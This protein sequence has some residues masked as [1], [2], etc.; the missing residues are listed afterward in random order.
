MRKLFLLIFLVTT[1]LIADQPDIVIDKR[2]TYGDQ[3]S[4]YDWMIDSTDL[5]GWGIEI[6]SVVSGYYSYPTTKVAII[7]IGPGIDSLR[8][9]FYRSGLQMF[10]AEGGRL[11]VPVEFSY[12][13]TWY[14]WQHKC[15]LLLLNEGW[16]LGMEANNDCLFDSLKGLTFFGSYYSSS[17][18][19]PP[20]LDS[21]LA[22]DIDSLCL[23]AGPSVSLFFPAETLL[24]GNLSTYNGIFPAYPFVIGARSFYGDGE[25]IIFENSMFGFRYPEDSLSIAF[26]NT[27]LNHNKPYLRNLL[28]TPV[29]D[30]QERIFKGIPFFL[31]TQVE[32]I[33]PEDEPDQATMDEDESGVRFLQS[34]GDTVANSFEVSE[35]SGFFVKMDVFLGQKAV[36]D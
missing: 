6:D 12:Y 24:I 2:F 13:P 33:D 20:P 22:I 36:E 31:H 14:Q 9:A 5:W 1:G 30:H 11:L 17:F 15:N 27:A 34:D 25:V 18:T 21:T 7:S 35:M 19:F 10:V 32:G 28:T 26:F 4:T 3:S 29:Q 8:L 16:L 23:G